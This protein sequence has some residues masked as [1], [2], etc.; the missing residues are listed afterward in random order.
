MFLMETLKNQGFSAIPTP[1]G[2]CEGL[3]YFYII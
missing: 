2:V 3:R 1:I